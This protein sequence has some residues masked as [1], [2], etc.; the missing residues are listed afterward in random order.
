M[1]TMN[2]GLESGSRS[3][4]DSSV[5]GSLCAIDRL[6]IE[7]PDR[8]FDGEYYASLDAELRGLHARIRINH[9]ADTIT[10]GG[11][12][13]REIPPQYQAEF[14]RLRA[15]YRTILGHLDRLIRS[16]DLM[17]D[18]PIE[19]KDVFFARIRELVSILRRH[20]AEENRLF[21]LAVWRDTGG[22]S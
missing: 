10:G 20:E 8:M 16:V 17:V 15:E 6:L 5:R 9:A 14:D 2:A 7:A 4:D 19:D 18:F 3:R 12:D 13:L 11:P 22:E 1:T 21:Y